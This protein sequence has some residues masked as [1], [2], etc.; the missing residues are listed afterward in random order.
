MLTRNH[1]LLLCTAF[2]A[3]QSLHASGGSKGGKLVMP[4]ATAS[5]AQRSAAAVAVNRVEEVTYDDS[6]ANSTARNSRTNPPSASSSPAPAAA[7]AAAAAS[8]DTFQTA[9]RLAQPQPA[10]GA[11]AKNDKDKKEKASADS[12]NGAS[13]SSSASSDKKPN[14]VRSGAWYKRVT[15]Q[16]SN[17]DD[18]LDNDLKSISE[19]NDTFRVAQADILEHHRVVGAS[20]ANMISARDLDKMQRIL[21]NAKKTKMT[22]DSSVRKETRKATNAWITEQRTEGEAEYA[23]ACHK[24]KKDLEEAFAAAK[25]KHNARKANVARLEAI[26]CQTYALEGS[27]PNQEEEYVFAKDDSLLGIDPKKIR[28]VNAGELSVLLAETPK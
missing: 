1:L 19:S 3:H 10:N 20:F 14:V 21:D 28:G 17:Q 15:K 16:L 18:I 6:Q 23:E 22:T 9:P 25:T 4:M 7:A 26:R 8:V 24:A 2:I 11:Q 27:S 5:D 13:S 12:A